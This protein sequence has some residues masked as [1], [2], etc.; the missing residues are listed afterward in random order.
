MDGFDAEFEELVLLVALYGPV[1]VC[2]A[3]NDASDIGQAVK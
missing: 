3:Y 1:A 2:A